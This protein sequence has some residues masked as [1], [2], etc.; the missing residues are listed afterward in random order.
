MDGQNVCRFHGGK[1]PQAL[2]GAQKRLARDRAL[3]QVGELLAELGEEPVPDPLSGLELAYARAARMTA[4]TGI[5][6]DGLNSPLG[7]NRFD[8]EVIHPLVALH[9]EWLDRYARI[10]KLALDAGIDERRLTLAERDAKV[11]LDAVAVA[12]DAAGLTPDQQ[13]RFRGA[14]ADKLRALDAGATG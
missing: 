14:L 7:L 12:I 5:L 6:V 4:A 9:G 11:L 10:Q 1:S 13:G 8:E 2:A 3:G